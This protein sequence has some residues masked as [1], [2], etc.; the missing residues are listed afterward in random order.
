MVIT[1]IKSSRWAKASS[2]IIHACVCLEMVALSISNI[3]V[4]S[5]VGGEALFVFIIFLTLPI[6][7][8]SIPLFFTFWAGIFVT[9]FI[10]GKELIDADFLILTIFVAFNI[11]L[12]AW[13]WSLFLR[14]WSFPPCLAKVNEFFK[15][16][17]WVIFEIFWRFGLSGL[18]IAFGLSRLL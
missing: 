18:L 13:W 6:S 8:F 1:L 15:F 10:T 5:Y 4:G 16:E 3:S 9:K 2:M 14:K 17:P 12:H 7:L 11:L